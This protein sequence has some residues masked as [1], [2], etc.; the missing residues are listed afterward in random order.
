MKRNRFPWTSAKR[1]K[2]RRFRIIV[3]SWFPNNSFAR[4]GRCVDIYAI[5]LYP[6][7]LLIS[8]SI[9]PSSFNWLRVVLYSNNF[10]DPFF[11]KLQW[12]FCSLWKENRL[13]NTRE[14][15]CE[16]MKR[17]FLFVAKFQ[18]IKNGEP[19][20]STLSKCNSDGKL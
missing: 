14:S 7:I 2:Y 3:L 9:V 4:T 20:H 18:T 16:Q 8:C 15:Q 10:E 1:R 13:T 19:L 5:I 12:Q 17:V 11:N 6:W